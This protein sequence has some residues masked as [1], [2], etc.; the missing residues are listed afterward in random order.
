MKDQVAVK[1]AAR[2][3]DRCQLTSYGFL[4]ERIIAYALIETG[5]VAICRLLVIY[6]LL[7]AR[8]LS[9]P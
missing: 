6:A 2:T 4:D 3:S 5:S 1:P 8:P 7:T 9:I